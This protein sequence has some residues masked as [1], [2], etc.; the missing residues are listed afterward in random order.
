MLYRVALDSIDEARRALH[1]GDIEARAKPVSRAMDAVA[2]LQATLDYER[3]G[4]LSV[5]L[6]RFYSS[7]Q[8]RLI[9]GH[10][11]QSDEK[12]AEAAKLLSTLADAWDQ[13][14]RAESARPSPAIEETTPAAVPAYDPYATVQEHGERSFMF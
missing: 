11:E 8:V 5:D 10:T 12:F 13:L 3:G 6:A 2:E 1:S 4:A 9:D 14:A 7:V